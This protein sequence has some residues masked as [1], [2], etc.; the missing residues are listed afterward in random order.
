MEIAIHTWSGASRP[1]RFSLGLQ[2]GSV[3]ADFDV[4]PDGRAYLVRISFDGYGCCRAPAEVGRM[5]ADDSATLLAMV[6]QRAVE[7][8]AL[9]LRAYFREV[10]EALWKD[11]FEHHDLLYSN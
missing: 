3:F 8:G 2:G 10:C 9:L 6:E 5:N 4:D 11:A 7:G 1:C